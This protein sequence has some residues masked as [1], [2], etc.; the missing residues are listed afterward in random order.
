MNLVKIVAIG[1]VASLALTGCQTN[2]KRKVGSTV[3][4]AP[5]GNYQG[6]TYD[7][8]ALVEN[9]EAVTAE[10]QNLTGVVHFAY[11]SSELDAAAQDILMQ[12][13][14]FLTQ[15]QS[16]RVLVA[17]H[18]DERGSREYNMALGER[19]AA[20]VRDF[21]SANGV[22]TASIEIMSYGEEHPVATG[23]DEESW[24]QNRRAELSY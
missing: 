19:R 5:M 1:A 22:N 10:A 15:N 24:A 8:G 9:T 20:S 17:G 2:V 23:S 3:A 18:T 7:G 11:D 16:A 4:V 21:L 14:A 12:H 13:V 6:E